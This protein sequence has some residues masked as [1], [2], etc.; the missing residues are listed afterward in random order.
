MKPYL[1]RLFKEDLERKAKLIAHYSEKWGKR[2][3]YADILRE[4]QRLK[5]EDI[6]RLSD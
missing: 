3:A 5:V 6:E 1:L 2:A 4:L